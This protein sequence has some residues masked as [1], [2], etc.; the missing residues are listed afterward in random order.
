MSAPAPR[1]NPREVDRLVYAGLLGLGA[2][3][4]IQLSDKGELDPGQTV[5]V[6]AFAVAVPLLAAGLVADYARHAGSRVPAFY[7]LVG[8]LGAAGAVTGFGGLFFHFGLWHGAA[9]VAA[10]VVAFALIRKL[11]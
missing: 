4:V 8:F 3:A 9:F 10:G 11:D 1:P 5:A 6:Y 7:D 2:A